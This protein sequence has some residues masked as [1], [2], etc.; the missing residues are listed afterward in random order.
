MTVIDIR[1]GNEAI[2]I[3]LDVVRKGREH[4]RH[5]EECAHDAIEIDTLKTELTCTKCGTKINPV[6]WIAMIAEDWS[7]INWRYQEVARLNKAIDM[8]RRTKCE[9][10]G[11][12]TK[13]NYPKAELRDLLRNRVVAAIRDEN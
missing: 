8:K 7:R 1:D 5:T 4:R 12:V 6:E 13:V 2:V 3:S 10:C 11:K 9:H